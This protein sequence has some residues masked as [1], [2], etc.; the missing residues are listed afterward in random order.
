MPVEIVGDNTEFANNVITYLKRSPRF[1]A[2]PNGLRLEVTTSPDL[3]I[4]L[5]S[6]TGTILT[7]YTM[8][9]AENESSIWNAQQ[10]TRLFHSD[11]F[12]LGYDISKA[13]RSILLGS[14]VILSS[15]TNGN[16]EQNRNTIFNR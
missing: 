11:T 9:A 3:S 2:N 8:T 1:T 12:G 13:Q 4:C 16:Q 10:L 6:R 7:C 5:K 14:S 15:Q